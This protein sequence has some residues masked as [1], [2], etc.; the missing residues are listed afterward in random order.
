MAAFVN[1]IVVAKRVEFI[2]VKPSGGGPPFMVGSRVVV[3]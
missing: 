3:R 1:Q 2:V